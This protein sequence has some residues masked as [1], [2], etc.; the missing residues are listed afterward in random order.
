M[1][2]GIMKVKE[3]H[4]I[5][6]HSKK[7]TLILLRINYVLFHNNFCWENVTRLSCQERLKM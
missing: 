7:Y 5:Q 4:G 2:R 1:D 6:T 3:I